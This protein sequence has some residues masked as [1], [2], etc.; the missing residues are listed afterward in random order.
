MLEF[1]IILLGFQFLYSVLLVLSNLCFAAKM[2]VRVDTRKQMWSP[3][4]EEKT[5]QKKKK[6]KEN[7]RESL[8]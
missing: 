3:S 4:I 7:A 2:T 8:P 5:S 6:I 1:L